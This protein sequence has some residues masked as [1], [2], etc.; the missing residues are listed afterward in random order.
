MNVN[1]RVDEVRVLSGLNQR[2]FAEMLDIDEA[3]YSKYKKGTLVP[4]QVILDRIV[5]S[6]NFVSVEWL[7]YGNG[8]MLKSENTITQEPIINYNKSMDLRTQS[9]LLLT[10]SQT[11]REMKD[12]ISEL[13]NRLSMIEEPSKKKLNAGS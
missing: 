3:T 11:V 2:K 9:E 6:F 5:K 10:L 12:R 13:E 7:F 8:E 1:Q 4:G